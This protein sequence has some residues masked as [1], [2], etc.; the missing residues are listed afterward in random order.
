MCR[1][2]PHCLIIDLMAKEKKLQLRSLFL[3]P[4]PTP[5][6]STFAGCVK[7][8]PYCNKCL[9]RLGSVGQNTRSPFPVFI[10]SL[11]PFNTSYSFSMLSS[12]IGE[13]LF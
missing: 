10:R 7:C 4:T 6:L 13:H 11:L 5:A 1:N 2:F 8:L 12:Q 9:S 3:D